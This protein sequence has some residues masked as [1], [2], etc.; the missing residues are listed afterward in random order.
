[1][2][3]NKIIA[4]FRMSIY[5]LTN[6]TIVSNSPFHVPSNFL[7]VQNT[8]QQIFYLNALFIFCRLSK[9]F[10]QLKERKN[11]YCFITPFFSNSL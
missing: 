4:I 2:K 6:T 10:P 3:K 9:E 1:M 11:V 5:V 8:H 7:T